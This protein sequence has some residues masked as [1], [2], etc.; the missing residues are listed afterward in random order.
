MG[1]VG[2]GAPL[3]I[4]EAPEARM[5]GQ[6]RSSGTPHRSAERR[7]GMRDFGSGRAH[8]ACM[9]RHLCLPEAYQTLPELRTGR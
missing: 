7:L 5:I 2:T 1:F 3:C 6:Q 8:N 9:A 4:G